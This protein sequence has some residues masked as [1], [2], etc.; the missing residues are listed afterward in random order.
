MSPFSFPFLFIIIIIF[1]SKKDS[2]FL[3]TLTEETFQNLPFLFH[4]II[5]F[6]FTERVFIC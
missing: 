1:F 3:W 4:D 2:L 6:F 5:I